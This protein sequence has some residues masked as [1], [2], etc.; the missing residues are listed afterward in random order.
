MDYFGPGG[1]SEGLI[2]SRRGG[3]TDPRMYFENVRPKHKNV[4]KMII[5]EVICI[6]CASGDSKQ[7]DK[8][9]YLSEQQK[10][11]AS[12]FSIPHIFLFFLFWC[13][14]MQSVRLEL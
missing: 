10:T 2:F 6:G 8:N 12:T 11:E 3:G 5:H 13:F 14:G 4:L 9:R 7:L 1:Q